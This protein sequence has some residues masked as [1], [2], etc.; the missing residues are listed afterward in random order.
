MVEAWDFILVLRITVSSKQLIYHAPV[1]TT[2][3]DHKRESTYNEHHPIFNYAWK[4]FE[5]RQGNY[6]LT[7]YRQITYPIL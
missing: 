5:N 3:Q 6:P 7:Q 2:P 1:S 4:K